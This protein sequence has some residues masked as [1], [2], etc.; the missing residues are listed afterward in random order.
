MPIIVGLK[1]TSKGLQYQWQ[2]TFYTYDPTLAGATLTAGPD[3]VIENSFPDSDVFEERILNESGKQIFYEYGGY[4]EY[5]VSGHVDPVEGLYYSCRA[6]SQ[7]SAATE[8]YVYKLPW[9]STADSETPLA[10]STVN[11]PPGTG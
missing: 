2:R 8:V 6:T 1:I 5:L 9:I 4:T 3:Y 10:V 11:V 7:S